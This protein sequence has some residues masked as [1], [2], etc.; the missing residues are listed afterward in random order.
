MKNVVFV[1]GNVSKLKGEK[2][3]E[4]RSNDKNYWFPIKFSF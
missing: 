1:Q 2:E 3:L 4:G